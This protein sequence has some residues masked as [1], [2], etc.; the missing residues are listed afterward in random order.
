[1]PLTEGQKQILKSTA[2]IFKENGKEITSILYKHLF[3]HHPDLL[4]IFNRTNQKNGTQPFALANTVFLAIKN[5]DNLEVLM[6]QILLIAHKH[7]AS[8][9][10]P[11][12]YPIVGKYFLIAIDEFLGGM[13]DPDIRNAWSAAYKIISSIFIDIEKKLYAE[14]GDKHQ[15]GFIPFKIIEKEIIAKGPIAAI[16]LE[17]ND[18]GKLQKYHSGQYIT[19]QIKKDGILHIRHYSLMQ[20]YD[21]KSYR[22]AIKQDND[23][24]PKGIVSTEIIT[25]YNVGDIIT[26]SLPA[27]TFKLVDSDKRCLFIAVGVGITAL[28]AMI[29]DLHQ[30]GKADL[31]TL[32]HCVTNEDQAIFADDMRRILSENRYHVLLQGKKQ[33]HDLIKKIITPETNVYLCGSVQFINKVE[34]YLLKCNHPSSQIHI[35][36]YQ[37]ALSLVKGAVKNSATTKPI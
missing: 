20:P 21:G 4:N 33:L 31:V 12:H 15:Q 9:V 24:E 5:I 26:L 34:E 29:Y 2:P 28:S 14:L 3:A 8:T 17:R 10:R 30:Q 1:M 25:K 11:E 22:I 19:L 7:R 13:A 32:I 23:H 16:T 27:G 6:P 36:T 18:G 37:P 35:E